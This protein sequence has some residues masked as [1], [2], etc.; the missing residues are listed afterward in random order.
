MLTAVLA[1]I[2]A[3]AMSVVFAAALFYQW[4]SRDGAE[5]EQ[6]RARAEQHRQDDHERWQ[7]A[8]LERAARARDWDAWLDELAPDETGPQRVIP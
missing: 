5:H 8:L 7:A 4:G 3:W 6:W 2:L 1:I